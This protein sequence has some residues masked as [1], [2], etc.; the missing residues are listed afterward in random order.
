LSPLKRRRIEH[1]LNVLDA[2]RTERI[3]LV[4]EFLFSAAAAAAAQ[5]PSMRPAAVLF[6]RFF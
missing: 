4:E 6:N 3:Q 1:V 5:E 2:L